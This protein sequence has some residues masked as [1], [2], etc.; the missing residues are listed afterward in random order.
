MKKSIKNR[1]IWVLLITVVLS[2]NQHPS[3]Q[4]YFVD[5]QQRNGFT[6]FDL[7]VSMINIQDIDMNTEQREAYESVKKL[8]ILAFKTENTDT[9][10]YK[11]ELEHVKTILKDP[12]YEELVRGGNVIDGKFTVKFLGD[13][14]SIDELIIFANAKNKGFIIARVLGNNMS[15]SKLIKL[16]SVIRD[17]KFED[18]QLS[19]FLNFVK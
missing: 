3:L 11:I 15:A 7:P 17:L 2:C 18:D 8:N 13:V 12:K 4:T 5:N 1:S 19:Q 6:S 16:Q 10:D 9:E 14:D